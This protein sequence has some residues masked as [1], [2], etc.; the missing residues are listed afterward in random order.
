[1]W[2]IIEMQEYIHNLKRLIVAVVQVILNLDT[3]GGKHINNE[4]IV[5]IW[6]WRMDRMHR[7][8]DIN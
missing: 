5:F 1:M 6:K 8:M 7:R 2:D 4:P 3:Y